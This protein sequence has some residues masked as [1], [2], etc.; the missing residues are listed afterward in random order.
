MPSC[1]YTARKAKRISVAAIHMF[2]H[3]RCWLRFF[4]FGVSEELYRKLPFKSL[5]VHKATFLVSVGRHAG[6]SDFNSSFT[7]DHRL[8]SPLN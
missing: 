5:T 8:P 7:P 4:F 2:Q 3:L 1:V 6:V